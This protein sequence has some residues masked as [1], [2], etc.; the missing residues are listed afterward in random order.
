[1]VTPDTFF[2]VAF[3]VFPYFKDF[4]VRYSFNIHSVASL[5]FNQFY[6]FTPNP[7]KIHPRL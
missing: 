3:D 7:N 1:M 5:V 6:N 4:P 2:P